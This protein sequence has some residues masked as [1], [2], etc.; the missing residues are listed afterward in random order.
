MSE[1]D[2]LN[3]TITRLA[4]NASKTVMETLIQSVRHAVYEEV[5][6]EFADREGDLKSREIEVERMAQSKAKARIPPNDI[7]NA[8][9]KVGAA[10]AVLEN[11]M[12]SPA[13]RQAHLQLNKAIKELQTAINN[14][15]FIKIN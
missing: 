1:H 6:H 5:K 10:A 12:F 11:V 13:E 3:T 14:H 2:R 9:A 8:A 15:P 4:E 7:L